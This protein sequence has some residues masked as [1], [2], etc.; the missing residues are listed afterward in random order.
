L[1]FRCAKTAPREIEERIQEAYI[2][3]LVSMGKEQYEAAGQTVNRGLEL[4]RTNVLLRELDVL[5]KKSL[6]R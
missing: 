1:G 4:D 5:I 3:A 6:R 2:G